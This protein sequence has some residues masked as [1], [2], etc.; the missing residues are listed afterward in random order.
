M[1]MTEKMKTKND[2]PT[3]R[4]NDNRDKGSYEKEKSVRQMEP[5]A[6]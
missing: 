4:K 1:P 6:S 2:T 5:P 3:Y